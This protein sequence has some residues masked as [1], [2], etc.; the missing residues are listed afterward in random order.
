MF[1]LHQ[2]ITLVKLF[3]FIKSYCLVAGESSEE[4]PEISV[5]GKTMMNHI[6]VF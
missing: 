5:G 2:A 6:D 4:D 1:I 3:C